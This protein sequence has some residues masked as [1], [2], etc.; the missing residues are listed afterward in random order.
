LGRKYYLRKISEGQ[1]RKDALRA[2]KRQI[3]DAVYRHLVA[4]A[5]REARR[6]T[7]DDTKAA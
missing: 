2:L 3:S 4:D 7:R 5:K 1:S 6:A